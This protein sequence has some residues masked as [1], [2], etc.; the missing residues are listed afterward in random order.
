MTDQGRKQ[1][2]STSEQEWLTTNDVEAFLSGWPTDL[3][4]NIVGGNADNL[5]KRLASSTPD[6]RVAAIRAYL[7]RDAFDQ[8]HDVDAPVADWKR[9]ANALTPRGSTVVLDPMLGQQ[10]IE[11]PDVLESIA[12]KTFDRLLIPVFVK[13]LDWQVFFSDEFSF[14]EPVNDDLADH[15]WCWCISDKPAMVLIQSSE[16]LSGHRLR[17]TVTC[18]SP[19]TFVCR[20]GDQIQAYAANTDN[21]KAEFSFLLQQASSVIGVEVTFSGDPMLPANPLDQ[22]KALYFSYSDT[23]IEKIGSQ[24]L[25][26]GAVPAP[27]TVSFLLDRSVRRVLHAQGF[28]EVQTLATPWV[29]LSALGGVRSCYDYQCAFSYRDTD[30]SALA[31][32]GNAHAH[33]YGFPAIWY[34]ARRMPTP[35][36]EWATTR[37]RF[38]LALTSH[39]I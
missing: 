6:L 8:F 37:E 16:A 36:T 30:P 7:P 23:S 19:G 35:G 14:E 27:N 29:G 25:H 2:E 10:L 12:L 1:S 32:F 11:N 21:L 39:A 4:V 9:M 22:R 24:F 18:T 17:F 3:P 34:Q 28:F 26:S 38:V 33:H 20:V 15:R 13:P 5:A 31:A